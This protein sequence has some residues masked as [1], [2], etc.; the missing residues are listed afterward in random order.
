[1][2]RKFKIQSFANITAHDGTQPVFYEIWD[3]IS[4]DGEERLHRNADLAFATEKEAQEW[5]SD[6]EF[7][8]K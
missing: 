3:V 8:R 1:M 7:K 2:S 4:V 5:I 6:Q